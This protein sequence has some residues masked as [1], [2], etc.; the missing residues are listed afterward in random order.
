MA[1]V[2]L[3]VVA[4]EE[5][6]TQMS[7]A[8]VAVAVLQLAVSASELASASASELSRHPSSRP[9]LFSAESEAL[10]L[11]ETAAVLVC[12]VSGTFRRLRHT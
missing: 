8:V 3:P 6:V 2:L 7:A 12:N 9:S 5:A 4:E 10:A 11:L 1:G